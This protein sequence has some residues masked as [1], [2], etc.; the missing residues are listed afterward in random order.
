[1]LFEVRSIHLFST[2]VIL[3]GLYREHGTYPTRLGAGWHSI[4]KRNCAHTLTDYGQCSDARPGETQ[5]GNANT[6]HMAKVGIKPPTLEM[7]VKDANQ[8]F[9]ITY[10]KLRQRYRP[11]CCWTPMRSHIFGNWII[12]VPLCIDPE[13]LSL[14]KV[15]YV[16]YWFMI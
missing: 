3:L 7:W 11:G 6:T 1:M 2:P 14:S 8:L 5:G 4:T 16:I 9:F 15:L 10:S 13:F 12:S